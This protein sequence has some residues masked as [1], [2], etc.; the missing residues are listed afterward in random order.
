MDVE[1]EVEIHVV[2]NYTFSLFLYIPSYWLHSKGQMLGFQ[3]TMKL[4]K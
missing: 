2:R 3:L 1:N 4:S